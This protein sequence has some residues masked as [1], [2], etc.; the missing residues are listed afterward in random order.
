MQ[1]QNVEIEQSDDQQDE[2]PLQKYITSEKKVIDYELL[3]HDEI[4]EAD[5]ILNER[6]S[7][8][9]LFCGTTFCLV[10]VDVS[11]KIILCANVG[12]SRAVL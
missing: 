10:L 4:L 9:L 1:Q 6:L 8:A 2:N 5:K 12:D 11:N 3:I 7:K